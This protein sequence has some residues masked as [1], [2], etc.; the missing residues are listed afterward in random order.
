LFCIC[1]L[2]SFYYFSVD[3]FSNDD[4]LVSEID[5][6]NLSEVCEVIERYESANTKQESDNTTV[7]TTPTFEL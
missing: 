3:K 5:L 7:N 2:I 4:N 6:Q 1:R